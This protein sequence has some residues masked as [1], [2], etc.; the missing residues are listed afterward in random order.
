MSYLLVPEK[1]AVI[2]PG[3][4]DA[5]GGKLCDYKGQT[6]TVAPHSITVAQAARA[7]GIMVPSPIGYRYKFPKVGGLHP[8]R[9]D[10]KERA[11]FLTLHK[12]AY[13]LSEI[14]TGKTHS[15]L[16][17]SDFLMQEGIIRKA[18][19]IAP[20][21]TLNQ[22]WENSIFDS[23]TRRTCAVL[24]GSA[25]RR[26]K[27]FS[28][29]FDFYVINID[30]LSTITQRGY[31]NRKRLVSVQLMRDD[32]DLII[33]D[34][35][36]EFRSSST[37]KFHLL[38]KLVEKVPYV[39][40]LTGA[41]T[42]QAPTD[43]WSE[44]KL[45]NGDRVSKF[46]TTFRQL[47]MTQATAYIWRP[48]K[49]ANEIVFQAMQPAIRYTRDEIE[50]LPGEIKSSRTC[51]LT[52]VQKKHYKDLVDE[53]VT[54]FASGQVVT[55]LN[56]GVL[57]SKLLQC[58]CGVIY[59]KAGNAIEVGA[60]PRIAL[61]NEIIEQAGQK[62][63]V[64]VPFTHVLKMVYREVSKHWDAAMV[65]GDTPKGERN[66]IF[67]AFQKSDKPHVIV[68]DAG[69][70]S[71]GL[72]LTE[73]STII[74]YAPDDSNNTYTQANG[75]IT[76][77]GQRYVANIIHL[78]SSAGERKIYQRNAERGSLQGILLEMIEEARGSPIVLKS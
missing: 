12:R 53:C 58:A 77:T 42:P 68:A 29:D 67:T 13:D 4:F 38:R 56:E 61:V 40:G 25:E 69:C 74:W 33:I 73:A 51:E 59:D 66:E 3:A 48:R 19:I 1:K 16:Y 35:L 15:T 60:Q 31:D 7:Q 9:A 32:I 75:R 39:W 45:V 10:Q 46:F 37:N 70:M 65:Y 44:C 20:L 72:T 57:R 6:I 21:S 47:T 64:F 30:G 34:E 41:P 54:V 24:Y 27:L 5:V 22:V 18:L 26:Q 36:A 71:H 43:A 49:E 17:A 78:S 50:D 14:G 8:A 55:A 63:L 52:D 11:A 23:F 62:V 2:F 28:K 76:R